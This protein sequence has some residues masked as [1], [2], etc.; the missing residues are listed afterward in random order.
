MQGIVAAVMREA[1]YILLGTLCFMVPDELL[2]GHRSQQLLQLWEPALGE[3]AATALDTL[4]T[5][6]AVSGKPW[7]K[8]REEGKE[9]RV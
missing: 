7:E 1:G 8:S 4:Y 5:S 3:G 2:A 9:T 6:N